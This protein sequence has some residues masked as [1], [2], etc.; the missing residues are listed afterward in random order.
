[1]RWILYTRSQC[2][3][4]YRFILM[5]YFQLVENHRYRSKIT[6]YQNSRRSDKFLKM[7][8]IN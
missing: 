3:R 2:S 1:M 5:Q 7:S 8:A 6:I 4:E